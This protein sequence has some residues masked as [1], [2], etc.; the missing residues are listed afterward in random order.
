[1]A[2]VEDQVRNSLQS[3]IEIVFVLLQINDVKIDCNAVQICASYTD[4]MFN[5]LKRSSNTMVMEAEFAKFIQV[6]F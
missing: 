2:E 4:C 5:T 3:V 6:F 1:V